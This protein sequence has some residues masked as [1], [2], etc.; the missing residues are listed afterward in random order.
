MGGLKPAVG[1]PDKK[2]KTVETV[3]LE[4]ETRSGRTHCDRL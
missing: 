2:W 4:C 3:S 1:A